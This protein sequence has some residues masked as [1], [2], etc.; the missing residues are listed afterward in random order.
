MSQDDELKSLF[1]SA[2][3]QLCFLKHTPPGDGFQQLDIEGFHSTDG[4]RA[5]VA[6]I[7]VVIPQPAGVGPCRRV[8]L[9]LKQA[10]AL[11]SQSGTWVFV[12]VIDVGKLK[13]KSGHRS[14]GTPP[15]S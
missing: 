3:Y 1:K 7:L 15:P 2:G 5:L 12:V 6:T 13:N 14:F 10:K 8:A 9:C 11:A 4:E